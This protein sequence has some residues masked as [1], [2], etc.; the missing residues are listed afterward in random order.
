M[1]KE[2]TTLSFSF[3]PGGRFVFHM[4]MTHD[5]LLN[6]GEHFLRSL[7]SASVCCPDFGK[8]DAPVSKQLEFVFE[9]ICSAVN[10]P[11]FAGVSS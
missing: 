3:G 1:Q 4:P 8:A 6:F 2:L 9:P 7:I 5:R 10:Q 11:E